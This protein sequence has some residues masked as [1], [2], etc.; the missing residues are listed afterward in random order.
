MTS[1]NR[2]QLSMVPEVTIG[3]T[4]GSPRMR[5]IRFTGENLEF[6]PEFL[7]SDE[8]RA[9][10][11]LGAPT[12]IMQASLGSIN[13]EISYPSENSPLARLF[14]SALCST[15]TNMPS[16]DNDGVADSVITDAGTTTDTFVVA[17]GG[18]AVKAGH[19]VKTTGFTNSANNQVFR[20]A[21]STG[22]TV[23]GASLSLVAETAPPA[24]ARLKVVGFAGASGDITA[25][26]GGLASTT[27]D[28]TTLGL[29]VGQWIKIGGTAA[30]DK[31]ATAALNGW[32]RIIAVTANAIT[33]DNKPS[34]W[35]TDAGTGKTIKV[36]VG[37]TMKNGLA[38]KSQTI[39][40]GYLAQGVPSYIKYAGMCV[41]TFELN[42]ASRQK[43][44]W[45]ANFLGMSGGV[46]TTPLDATID[47]ATTGLIMAGNANV[48]SLAENGSGLSSPNWCKEFSISINNNLR[49]LEAVDAA[50]PVGIA[51]GECLVTGR[52]MTYFGNK[53]LLEKFFN[54]TPT[55]FSSRVAKNS[56]AIIYQVPSAMNK[57]GG[58]PSVSGKNT[59]VM[60]PLDWQ[61]FYDTTTGAHI[62]VDR[63]E[64]FE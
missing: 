52:S 35:T 11:M 38:V 3:T 6:R 23:V 36:F 30:G 43:V 48:S 46:D 49:T 55:S 41:N 28:F 18:A 29:V 8:I 34:G 2:V 9:D 15:W 21:S 26:A 32:A 63:F 25:A 61:A 39:E 10:R 54:N 13:G 22:T 27:L 16:F 20:A 1:A 24:A 37:D 60:L 47:A 7:D 62:I 50:S 56:Q 40:K 59:D 44:T 42:L 12:K 5:P 51:E 58:N 64:Y 14:E 33:L 53:D 45:T 4:P 19:L 31:F 17:S 57:G